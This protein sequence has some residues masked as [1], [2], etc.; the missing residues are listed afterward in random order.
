MSKP[1]GVLVDGTGMAV[2]IVRGYGGTPKTGHTFVE[3]K[4]VSTVAVGQP[5]PTP[6]KLTLAE[7]DNEMARG[8]EDLAALLIG[9]SV[10]SRTDLP[11]QLLEKINAR[12]ALRGE[13]AI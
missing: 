12:R 2:A 13:T 5:A 6:A 11:A 10:V 9:K 4:D 1:D 8:V 3:L 7:T